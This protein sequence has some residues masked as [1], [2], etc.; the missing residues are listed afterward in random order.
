MEIVNFVPCVLNPRSNDLLD[1]LNAKPGYYLI[2]VE[3]DLNSWGG[4]PEPVHVTRYNLMHVFECAS[5]LMA[6]CGGMFIGH[7][8]G[9]ITGYRELGLHD[10]VKEL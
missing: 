8:R 5:G 7:L 10:E 9:T 3:E 4:I 6:D 2:R 1:N